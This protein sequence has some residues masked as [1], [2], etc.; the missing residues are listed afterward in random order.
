MMVQPHATSR[1]NV[2]STAFSVK[3]LVQN[4]IAG[5]DVRQHLLKFGSDIALSKIGGKALGQL[6]KVIGRAS[7]YVLRIGQARRTVASVGVGPLHH[8]ATN[9]NCISTLRGG[10]WSPKLAKIF[11]KAKMKLNDKAN[12]VRIPGHKGP[13]AEAYHQ[14]IYDCL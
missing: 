2:V 7:K 11:K 8:I 14:R 3:N 13:H 9:K 10:P 1:Y 6:F 5:N 12:K 4:L